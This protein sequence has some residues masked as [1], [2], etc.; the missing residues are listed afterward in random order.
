M[1]FQR[2]R[3]SLADGLVPIGSHLAAHGHYMLAW[4]TPRLSLNSAMWL[5]AQPLR[6]QVVLRGVL[7]L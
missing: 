6:R 3:A 2:N 7:A 4:L 5:R 1:L